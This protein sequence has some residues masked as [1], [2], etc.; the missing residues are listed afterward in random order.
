VKISIEENKIVKTLKLGHHYKNVSHVI[1][2]GKNLFSVGDDYLVNMY[3]SSGK[4]LKKT[5][6]LAAPIS[7]LSVSPDGNLVMVGEENTGKVYFISPVEKSIISQNQIFNNTLFASTFFENKNGLFAICAGGN[8]H[9]IQVINPSSAKLIKHISGASI[10]MSN[11]LFKDQ[12]LYFSNHQNSH[13]LN[14]F[15]DFNTFK[16]GLNHSNLSHSTLTNYKVINPYEI[17]FQKVIIKTTKE[18]GRILS[19]FKDAD[20]YYVG[21][22]YF[23]LVYSSEGKFLYK[24]NEH[25]RGIRAITM[26]EFGDQKYLVTSG[27]DALIKFFKLKDDTVE[28]IAAFNLYINIDRQWVMWS[29]SGYFVASEDGAKLIGF[30]RN[31]QVEKSQFTTLDKFFDILFKPFELNQSLHTGYSIEQILTDKNERVVDLGEIKG[32]SYVLLDD[33][34]TRKNID[35]KEYIVYPKP[36]NNGFISSETEIE[37]QLTAIDGGAGIKEINVM[38]NGKLIVLDN[39][40]PNTSTL[41]KVKRNYTINL[42][43]GKNHIEVFAV[44]YQKRSS[45]KQTL[46]IECKAE[47]KASTN[48]YA[49]MIGINEYKNPK[50]NLNYARDD[51][52][53]VKTK[54][55]EV[56]NGIFNKIYIE[57]LLDEKATKENIITALNDIVAKSN[58]NDVFVLYYA[59]HG[60][61]NTDN[62]DAEYYLVPHDVIHLHDSEDNLQKLAFSA[63]ELKM[64]LSKIKAQK[65]LILLDACHSGGALKTLSSNRGAPEEKAIFQL[66]RS[67]GIVLISASE[68]EQ[69]ATEFKSL[70][71]G[72][73]TYTLLEA[74]EGKADG[75]EGDKKITVNE[76]KVYMEDHVPI[77]SQKFGGKFQYPTGFSSGQD[78]PIGVVK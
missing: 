10:L 29:N 14:E 21:T 70:G 15:L 34:Y 16:M 27:E 30:Q 55:S 44:N 25:I 62:N 23:L 64:Y 18:Q 74:L 63:S 42:I 28:P 7:S 6:K 53:S 19:C 46:E 32:E 2:S 35:K 71:H 11:L 67:S 56:A 8:S 54:L 24:I 37:L 51:A 20:I 57:S 77:Y 43:P 22:D 49:L 78:F 3:D 72:V 5:A 12:K 58:P 4:F 65:Q 38:C 48:L 59:G 66:A 69:F 50:N 1:H 26:A 41:E 47:F 36:I 17:N 45:F 52:Q 68:T 40:I 31:E 61:M 13:S 73:F 9:E 60:V 33:F 75:S 39:S 76:I